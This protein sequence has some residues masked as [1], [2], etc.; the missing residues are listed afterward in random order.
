MTNAVLPGPDEVVGGAPP[1]VH[2]LVGNRGLGHHLDGGSPIAHHQR[3]GAVAEGRLLWR[4]RKTPTIV[5]GDDEDVLR[6]A[7]IDG[8]EGGEQSRGARPQRAREVRGPH[9]RRK[10]H[11][12]R[13]D[14]GRLL[15]A[16]WRSRRS[17][18]NGVDRFAAERLQHIHRGIDAHRERVLVVAGDTPLPRSLL[19]SPKP[20]RKPS[21]ANGTWGH[22]RRWTRYLTYPLPESVRPSI[23]N[24]HQQPPRKSPALESPLFRPSP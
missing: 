11:S 8:V 10:V 13:G 19:P 22:R 23:H 18:V 1:D 15:L 24:G 20:P 12:R 21:A 3:R 9:P 5:G 17:E 16:V 7:G 4:F 2:N 6:R 14:S